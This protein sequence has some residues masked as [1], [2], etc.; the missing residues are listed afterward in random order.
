MATVFLEKQTVWFQEST[1][2]DYY[3]GGFNTNKFFQVGKKYSVEFDGEVFSSRAVE[4][5]D[6]S[7][8]TS[9]LVGNLGIVGLGDDTGEPCVVRTV[10]STNWFSVQTKS[11][12]VSHEL[13]INELEV[14][15]LA[16]TYTGSE[17]SAGSSVDSLKDLIVI[18]TYSDG[19][20]DEISDYELTGKIVEGENIITVTFEGL[21]TTF[22]VIGVPKRI[23]LKD[24][25]GNDVIY[26]GVKNIKIPT[27]DGG[28][29]SFSQGEAVEKY[30]DLALEEGEQI[31]KADE[32]ELFYKVTVKKPETLIPGNIA[33]GVDIAG[34]VGTLKA[35]GG[36]SSGDYTVKVIDY[37]G[38]VIAEEKLSTGDVFTLPDAPTHE[39][40]VFDGWSANVDVVNGTVAV[41]GNDIVVGAMYTTASGATEVDIDVNKVIG[42]TFG[43]TSASVLEGYT[44]IDWGDGTVD[45]AISH[46]YSDYGKYTIKIYGMTKINSTGSS[47]TFANSTT[48]NMVEHVRLC[49]SVNA[50]GGYAF[51][52]HQTLKSIVLH[53]GIT[54]IGGYAFRYCYPLKCVVLPSGITNDLAYAFEKCNSLKKIVLPSGITSI[55]KYAFRYCYSLESI[56]FPSGITSIGMEAFNECISLENIV[57]PSGITSIETYAFSKCYSLK[58]IVLP[59]GITSIGTYAFQYCTALKSIVLP[60]G[61]TSIANNTFYY[62]YSLESIVFPSGITSI[63]NYAFYYCYALKSIVLP[64]GITSIGK[65]AFQNCYSLERVVIPSNNL[66]I[67]SNAFANDVSVMEYDF[68]ESETIPSLSSSVF[69]SI[70]KATKMKVPAS[71]YDSWIVATNWSD[72]AN[73]IVAV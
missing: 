12:E 60:F 64:L 15:N 54:S 51:Q 8:F 63:G 20:T 23:V 62:C 31:V 27:E 68:S 37:D 49:G 45:T 21:T 34:V 40:L 28:I 61:I 32:G 1:E 48:R 55:G 19:T 11:T 53:S 14:Q 52:N 26:E 24:H 39:G 18:A 42:L 73:Y 65:Y 30:I 36:G 33:N 46:T 5:V 44:S 70:S 9:V 25:A 41:D 6:S 69:N 7:G 72:F 3:V 59:L 16:A 67:N 58:S 35:G 43:F 71:L 38:T 4:I 47:A 57:L 10:K 66:A 22:V 13:S 2:G 17:V 50:I 56:V 29:Q